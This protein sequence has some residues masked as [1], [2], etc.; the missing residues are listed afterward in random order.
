M[1]AKYSTTVLPTTVESVAGVLVDWATPSNAAASDDSYATAALQ[2]LAPTSDPLRATV[3]DFSAIPATAIV[4][5]IAV[6]IEAKASA[7]AYITYCELQSSGV[8]IGTRDTTDKSLT[9]SDAEY[10]YGGDG[11]LWGIVTRDTLDA[12]FGV[13][14]Q[15]VADPDDTTVSVDAI[16]VVVY[17]TEAT[18]GAGVWTSGPGKQTYRRIRWEE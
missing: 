13:Q 8:R 7:A 2:T 14:L 4:S 1:S 18:S 12:T 3:F 9:T 15:A 16:S 5:G 11:S 17:W 6:V 10:T